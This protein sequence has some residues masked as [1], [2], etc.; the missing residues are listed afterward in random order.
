MCAHI[1]SGVGMGYMYEYNIVM[2]EYACGSVLVGH[3]V[4]MGAYLLEGSL[5]PH[6]TQGSPS[7]LEVL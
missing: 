5:C 1:C 4:N 7:S 2:C 6:S 3:V